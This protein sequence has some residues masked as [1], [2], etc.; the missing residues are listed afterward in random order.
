MDYYEIIKKHEDFENNSKV[1]SEDE[2]VTEH[3]TYIEDEDVT[4]NNDEKMTLV[5]R[6]V[7]GKLAEDIRKRVK[8]TPD[9]VVLITEEETLYWLSELTAEMNY[10]TVIKCAGVEK[11]FNLSAAHRNFEALLN[12]LD[13]DPDSPIGEE[14]C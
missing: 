2:K 6:Q 9:A 7:E 11:K 12:W 10:R 13:E 4:L 1:V 14:V 5:E 3:R 8:A